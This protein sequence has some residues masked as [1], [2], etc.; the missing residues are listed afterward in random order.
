MIQTENNQ[1]IKEISHQD[2][3]ALYDSWEQLQSWQEVL[4]VLD[5]FFNDKKRPI[6]KQQIAR[7]YY[8]CSQVFDLFHVDFRQLL[9]RMEQQ[10]VELRSKKKV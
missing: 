8:A 1:P 3:Y 6:D 4:L 10:L 9:E 7:N 2:I 5:K